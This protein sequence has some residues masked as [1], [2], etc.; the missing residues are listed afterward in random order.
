MPANT[1]TAKG[2]SAVHAAWFDP[3]TG[4]S[5]L[6]GTVNVG[7]TAESGDSSVVRVTM[8][9]EVL[10]SLRQSASDIGDPTLDVALLLSWE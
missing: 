10:D 1:V 8:A 4:S 3:R 5:Q 7:V 6:V 9:P 2:S